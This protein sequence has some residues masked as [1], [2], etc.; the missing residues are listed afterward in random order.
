MQ[1]IASVVMAVTALRFKLIGHMSMVLSA[2]WMSRRSAPFRHLG[3]PVGHDTRT[4]WLPPDVLK[5]R[6]STSTSRTTKLN[7]HT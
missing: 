1:A 5:M 7:S 6:V 4:P 2:L 3:L